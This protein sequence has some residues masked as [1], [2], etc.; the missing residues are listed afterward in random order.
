MHVIILG[1]GRL[2]VRLVNALRQAGHTIT[3]VDREERKFR[4]LEVHE[5]ITRL[6]GDIL[7]DAVMKEVFAREADLFIAATGQDN[8]NLMVAQAVQK[9]HYTGRVLIRVFDPTLAKVYREMGLETVCPTE[10]A[11]TAMLKMIG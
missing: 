8:L 11:L 6:R 3:I 7:D 2:G 4:N 10:L 1:S 5:N 9:R